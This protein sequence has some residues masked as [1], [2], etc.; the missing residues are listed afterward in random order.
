M[1]SQTMFVTNLLS[2][3]NILNLY[4]NQ[5]FLTKPKQIEYIKFSKD[6]IKIIFTDLNALEKA[7]NISESVNEIVTII[8]NKINSNKT[9]LI[10]SGII[11]IQETFPFNIKWN[12]ENDNLIIEISLK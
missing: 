11:D 3:D 4:N 12:T 8:E 10:N 2:N 1:K 5:N 9:I 7:Y 6:K